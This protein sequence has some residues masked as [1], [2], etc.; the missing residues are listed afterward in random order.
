[1]SNI[2]FSEAEQLKLQELTAATNQFSTYKQLLLRGTYAGVDSRLVVE[3]V[4]FMDEMIKQTEFQLNTLRTQAAKRAL[5][6]KEA[7]KKGTK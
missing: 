5:E 3:A 1:M 2:V 6:P 4:G 7:K